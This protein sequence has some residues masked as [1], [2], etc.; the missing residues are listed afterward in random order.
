MRVDE[1]R[2]LHVIHHAMENR[3]TQR[4]AAALL[5][6]TDRHVRR[7]I[8]RVR[9]S[10]D[11][12]IVHRGRGQPSNRRIPE[13]VKAKVL[14]LYARRYADFGPTL[15]AEK[16]AEQA[17]LI[18][19]DETLREW[20]L[21]EGIT[22]FQ[23][24]R[25]PHRHW[26]E[27]KRCA[28]ELVQMD[29]SHHDWLEGRGPACVLMGYI[30]DATN[31]VWARFYEYEGTMS[32]MDSFKGYLQRRGLPMTV[33]CDKHTTYRSP[34]EPTLAEQLAGVEPQSQF[35]RAL[36]E[37]GV[38]L[39]H[40]HSKGRVERLFKTCQDR[41][42]KE[43]RLAGIAT[44][45]EANRFLERY[46]P[47]YNQRFAVKPA[48]RADLHRPLPAGCDLEAILCTKTARAVRNDQTVTH[49]GRWYQ[50]EEHLRARTVVVE[51]RLD[52]AIRIM[53]GGQPVRYHEIVSRP[54]RIEHAV[55][56]VL[57]RR[58]KTRPAAEHPWRKAILVPKGE[59]MAAATAT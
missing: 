56:P 57:L 15:A 9:V 30:D 24:R 16:L 12:G 52:G 19:S 55:S 23:R 3:I 45:A 25:R 29:G 41:L 6:L 43:L 26:R 49:H 14:R 44:M 38:A 33:Y 36:A 37:L 35:G 51:E 21:Q 32:A 13:K 31:R 47:I 42:V 5:G 20:L 53:A 1:L 54:V 7:I 8:Q 27:R 58:R 22:H 48:Q 10:G 39:I 18:I 50:I 46:L 40:A 4:A 34:A 11:G 28:G 2:R 17:G 59:R